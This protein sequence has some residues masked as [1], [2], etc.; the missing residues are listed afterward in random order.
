MHDKRS[1]FT[2]VELLAVLGAGS[3]VMGIGVALLTL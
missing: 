3:I 1:G 2:L